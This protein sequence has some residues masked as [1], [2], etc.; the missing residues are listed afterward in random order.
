[1]VIGCA[2]NPD[3]LTPSY[4]S[5]LQYQDYSCKQIGAES[6]MIER[7]VGEHYSSLD[8]K[9]SNDSGQMAA[10][11]IIFWPALFFLEGGDGAEAVEYKRMRGEYDAL[12]KVAIQK[13][14]GLTFNIQKALPQKPKVDNR[15]EADK[16]ISG[17]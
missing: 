6:A 17:K 16:R 5:P 4:V 15:T 12:Q 1:M 13:N 8:K 10:G 9:A 3:E 2:S 11:L 14:C 7:R